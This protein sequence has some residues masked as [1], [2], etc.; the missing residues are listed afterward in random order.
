MRLK[1]YIRLIRPHQWLK[2][3]FVFL[4]LFFSGGIANVDLLIRTVYAAISISLISSCI[5]CLND[6]IDVKADRL[7]PLKRNR[8]IA[9]GT[10]SLREA[11]TL[12]IVM[13]VLSFSLMSV[14]KLNVEALLLISIYLVLNVLYC[15]RLK[16]I[17]LVDVFIISSGFKL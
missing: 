6:V 15:I 12:M 17:P 7:H 2:N 13:G 9:K 4:P 10:V 11:Y 8:P 1:E 16:Q 5:Y 3:L 14:F